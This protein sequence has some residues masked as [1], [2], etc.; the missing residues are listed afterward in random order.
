MATSLT[1]HDVIGKEKEQPYFVETL[2]FCCRW[3]AR[4][5]RPFIHRRRTCSTLSAIPSWRTSK[6][7]S[8][9]RIPTTAPIRR[10]ALFLG[11]PGVPA[12]PSLVNMYKELAT[13][14]PGFERPDHGYPQSWAEQGAAAQH[15][16]DGGR[17]PRVLARQPG[18]KTFTDKVIAA[19]EREP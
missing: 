13:D 3:N 7:S 1:W 11:A 19:P 2:A 15:R 17:R 16:A 9:A 5:V 18:L 10:T 12:P 4:P 14:I 8:P 6:S